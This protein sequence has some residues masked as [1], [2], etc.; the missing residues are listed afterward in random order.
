M[1]PKPIRSTPSEMPVAVIPYQPVHSNQA[2]VVLSY[3]IAIAQI[4]A[5]GPLMKPAAVA[6]IP[7]SLNSSDS[8]VDS[9]VSSSTATNR[10]SNT[11][12]YALPMT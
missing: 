11:N 5:S 10:G 9:S 7:H 4:T 8:V 12:L 1:Q 3:Q 6:A 2:L